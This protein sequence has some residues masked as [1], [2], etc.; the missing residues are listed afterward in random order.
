VL[1]PGIYDWKDTLYITVSGTVLLG[2]GMATLTAPSTGRPCIHVGGKCHSVRIS[3]LSLEASCVSTYEG[4]TLLQWGDEGQVPDDPHQ[5]HQ[6]GGV[7]HDVYCLVGGRSLDRTVAVETMVKI[8]SDHVIGDNLWLWRAD[9]V[10]L[11]EGERPN[12]PDLSEYHVT[13]YG[14]V[15]VVYVVVFVTCCGCIC[16]M[17]PDRSDHGGHKPLLFAPPP[18]FAENADAMLAWRYTDRT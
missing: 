17:G 18:S 8:Y 4:S 16:S 5:G 6:L 13:E 7:L 11:R 2:L 15:R 3:G 14:Y 10:R 12:R 1:N 9:H